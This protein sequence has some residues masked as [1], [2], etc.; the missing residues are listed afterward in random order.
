MSTNE[1]DL[2]PGSD[3]MEAILAVPNDHVRLFKLAAAHM[4]KL[5]SEEVQ[6]FRENDA[7][8][9]P[10]PSG[11]K[12]EEVHAHENNFGYAR[13]RLADA[14]Q[15]YITASDHE[16]DTDQ[17]TLFAPPLVLGNVLEILAR[18]VG[19]SYLAQALAVS[20][21]TEASVEVVQS[22]AEILPRRD[23]GTM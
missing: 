12:N 10:H 21:V 16:E 6:L 18:E 3:P 15:V 17:M 22:T 7:V 2:V 14:C 13:R 19:A 23:A 4:V 11:G 5:R 8:N 20:P 9:A 1:P